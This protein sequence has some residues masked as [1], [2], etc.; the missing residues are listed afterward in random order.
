MLQPA[1]SWPPSRVCTFVLRVLLA[2]NLALA[3]AA[4]GPV[5]NAAAPDPAT[6]PP[7]TASL[8]PPEGALPPNVIYL[9]QTGH[10][11]RD[12][13]LTYWRGGGG[14]ARFG[15]PLSEQYEEEGADGVRRPVQL[16]DQARFELH[17]GADGGPWVELG[18]LGREALGPRA[19]PA[20][21]PFETT[22]ERE[23]VAATSHSLAFGFRDFWHAND[24]LRLLGYPLSEEQAAGALTVQYFE[25]GRLEYD[26]A[27]PPDRAVRMSPLGAQ[28]VASRGWPRPARLALTLNGVQPGQGQT[29]VADLFADRPVTVVAARFD[30]RPVAFFGRGFYH[31]ALVGV[32]PSAAPGP[33]TLAVEVR[34]GGGATKT[35]AEEVYVR[36]S[37]FPR[38]RIELPPEQEE[39]L[40]PTIAARE[41]QAVEPLYRLFTPQR[42]WSG[43]F[44]LPAEGP[45]T[46][47]FGILRA[48]N[49]GPYASWHNGLDIGAPEGAPVVAPAPG[50][51]VYAGPLAIR[52]NFV[53]ID[54]GL[55]VLTCYFHLYDIAVAEGQVVNSGDPI[56]RVGTTGLST[57]AHLH[58]EVRVSGAPVNPWQW[59]RDDV[60][61]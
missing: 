17:A 45:I 2:C 39:L 54:H 8:P 14:A 21:E 25:R 5:A 9:A 3:L 29:A 43:R 51:V 20:V 52:G 13:F 18:H 30:D 4:P 35:V 28:L 32:P 26:P 42:L 7:P 24:G 15:F 10:Y 12:D 22:P 23:H 31:R 61:P 47:E 58:W 34:D 33:H 49:D 56:G 48:Y 6:D 59:V 41:E 44:E 27:A 37:A 19:F 11:L 40:D 53:A 55:G 38:E 60:L 46:T 50:R 1:R 36:D 16:F 57:G